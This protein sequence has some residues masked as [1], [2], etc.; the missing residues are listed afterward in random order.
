M[1]QLGASIGS[2]ELPVHTLLT[3]VSLGMPRRKF[4]VKFFDT[5][6]A[7]FCQTLVPESSEFSLSY[8][9]PAAVLGRVVYFKTLCQAESLRRFKRLVKGCD[10][11]SI[12]IVTYKYDLLDIWVSLVKQPLDAFCPV[13]SG[14]LPLCYSLTP[15][16]QGFSEKED[17]AGAIPH[18]FVVLVSYTCTV[19]SKAIS[20]FCQK[21][22]RFLVHT[23]DRVFGII[24]TA[25]H[26]KDVLH[27]CDE[28][29]VMAGWYAPA[30]LQM[31]LVL[32]FL[33]CGRPAYE[34]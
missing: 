21:L 13:S 9:K 20:C 33:E 4:L 18:I 19:G 3:V 34:I 22:N 27:R 23:Y 17:A 26:L 24:W 14:S 10:I 7:P 29:R 1:L 16:G 5:V 2:L 12:E 31:R 8:V 6:Y 30:L 28:S 25:V 32:V 15:S 11:V